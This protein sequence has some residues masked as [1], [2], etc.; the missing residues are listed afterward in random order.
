LDTCDRTIRS[1]AEAPTISSHGGS[2]HLGRH[3]TIALK[4]VRLVTAT[5]R[6]A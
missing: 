1:G 5:D 4:R 2:W 6:G 3:R